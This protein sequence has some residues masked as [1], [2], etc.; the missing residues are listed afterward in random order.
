[1]R[2]VDREQPLE[3]GMNVQMWLSHAD[4]VQPQLD[5]Q[6]TIWDELHAES[7]LVTEDV[8]VQ[9]EDFVARLTGW[10][11]SYAAKL[12]VQR[13]AERVPGIRGVINDIGVRRTVNS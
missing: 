6:R 1:M 12:N 4:E 3:G 13:V 9:V 8:R 2:D 11:P 7:G 10:V 5:M